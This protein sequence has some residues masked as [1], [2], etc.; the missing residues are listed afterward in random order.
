[1]STLNTN[2]LMTKLGCILFVILS[3]E[4]KLVRTEECQCYTYSGDVENFNEEGTC[5]HCKTCDIGHVSHANCKCLSTTQCL[6]EELIIIGVV[7]GL[8][9]I[10]IVICIYFR[11]KKKLRERMIEEVC[12]INHDILAQQ[13]SQSRQDLITQQKFIKR[14]Y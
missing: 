8:I 9:I 4:W 2:I 10:A 5:K 6:K 13:T 14:D 11:R 3:L 7:I 12:I 1:M